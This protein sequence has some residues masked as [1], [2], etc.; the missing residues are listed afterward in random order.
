MALTGQLMPQLLD[1]DSL[2][3]N[4]SQQ[5]SREL[6]QFVGVFRQSFVDVQHGQTIAKQQRDGNPLRAFIP[7]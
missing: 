2:R 1:Q 4:L 5:K 7:L 3:P 6:S